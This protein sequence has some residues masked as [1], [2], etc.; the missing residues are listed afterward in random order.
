M[1]CRAEYKGKSTHVF[2]NFSSKKEELL[3]NPKHLWFLNIISQYFYVKITKPFTKKGSCMVHLL[4]KCILQIVE[5]GRQE[6][7]IKHLVPS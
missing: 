5:R 2:S 3:T 1:F 4:C 7:Y 6:K